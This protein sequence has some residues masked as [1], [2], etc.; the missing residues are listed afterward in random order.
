MREID[1]NNYFWQQ[2]VVR[3]RA[4]QPE[5]WNGHYYNRFDTLA[6]RLLNYEVELPPTLDESRKFAD[7]FTDFKLEMGRVMFIIE[8]LD[9]INVGILNLNSI[10]E[11]NGTFSIG[12][13]VDK[14]YRGKGYGTEAMRILLRYAF[15]ERRLNKFNASVLDGNIGSATMLK[16]LGCQ[17]EGIR[18]QVVYTDGRYMNEIL[19]GL[20][21]DEFIENEKILS[22]CL[23]SNKF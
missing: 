1:Y 4:M 13:Q 9:S 10:H 15:L 8:T 6:R 22:N 21:K 14:D 2:N 20:T 23:K 17:Q 7:T 19:F 16:K 3:L 11:R 5:D 12:M 18:R